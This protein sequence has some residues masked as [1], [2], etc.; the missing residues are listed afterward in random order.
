MKE[1]NNLW[2]FIF[3][4]KWEELVNAEAAMESDMISA[5]QQLEQQAKKARKLKKG[6]RRKHEADELE[7]K[8]QGYEAEMKWL[9]KKDKA[10]EENLARLQSR[11]RLSSYMSSKNK[12]RCSR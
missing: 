2:L 12:M 7:N 8:A 10:A 11:Y 9:Q 6:S 1:L 5:W 4:N 3:K